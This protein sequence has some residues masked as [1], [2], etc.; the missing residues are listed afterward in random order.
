[1]ITTAIFWRMSRKNKAL[2]AHAEVQPAIRLAEQWI[3]DSQAR[4]EK[5]VESAEQPLSSA[6]N[7]LLELRL[8][9]GR[10][11]Q[12]IKSL[13]LVREALTGSF[14]PRLA[15]QKLADITRLYL[16]EEGHRKEDSELVFLATS[17]GEMSCLQVKAAPGA[18]LDEAL[19]A[20]LARLGKASSQSPSTGGF[21]YFEEPSHYKECLRNAAWMEGLKTQRLM[22]IDP[23]GLSAILLSL[24]LS[25]DA[26]KVLQVF[27]GGID[28]TRALTGQSDRMGEALAQLSADSLKLRTIMEGAV[29]TRLT[30]PGNS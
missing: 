10:L 19:K 16:G 26:E 11:P 25:R 22:A 24:R 12:G 7:E 30:P 17:L 21:L 15:G 8:E 29:P 1:M 14:E 3:A 2:S 23:Q 18:P 5:L 27:Q 6:Q 28:S 4:V 13:K 9:A 20:A